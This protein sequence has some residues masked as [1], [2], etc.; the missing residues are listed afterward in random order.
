MHLRPHW[1]EQ[2]ILERF[3]LPWTFYQRN[4]Y[5]QHGQRLSAH[6]SETA[7]MLQSPRFSMIWTYPLLSREA[8]ESVV[9]NT[10][11]YDCLKLDHLMQIGGQTTSS[12]NKTKVGIS[13]TTQPIV[14]CSG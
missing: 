12:Q 3:R 4:F 6:I 5:F 14:F 2:Y 10:K 8:P 11:Q 7:E 9:F 13:K 1:R